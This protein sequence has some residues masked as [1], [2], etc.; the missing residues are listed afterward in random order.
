MFLWPQGQCCFVACRYGTSVG[1]CDRA[2]PLRCIVIG[3]RAITCV[4]HLAWPQPVHLVH[5]PKEGPR[6]LAGPRFRRDPQFITVSPESPATQLVSEEAAR[7]FT[8]GYEHDGSEL[9][10]FAFKAMRGSRHRNEVVS[11]ECEFRAHKPW[12]QFQG[13]SEIQA[14]KAVYFVK[15][16]VAVPMGAQGRKGSFSCCD[17]LALGGLQQA[18]CAKATA[19]RDPYRLVGEAAAHQYSLENI[20][21]SHTYRSATLWQHCTH[22][23]SATQCP[24]TP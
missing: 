12:D 2:G 9:T 23:H 3:S 14:D 10:S 16:W 4:R 18:V 5:K 21:T 20:K 19:S 1:Q 7:M 24:R 6:S 17:E 22:A 8:V 11:L 15:G 13:K